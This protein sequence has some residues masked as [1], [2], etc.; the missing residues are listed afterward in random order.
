M[1]PIVLK[2]ELFQNLS[3]FVSRWRKFVGNM[4][5]CFVNHFI[6]G[7]ACSEWAVPNRSALD[8]LGGAGSPWLKET[9][10]VIL[11][12]C[13]KDKRGGR[14]QGRGPKGWDKAQRHQMGPGGTGGVSWPKRRWFTWAFAVSAEISFCRDGAWAYWKTGPPRGWARAQSP[15][16]G[17]HAL[18]AL[19]HKDSFPMLQRRSAGR[20]IAA[21]RSSC[22]APRRT[23]RGGAGSQR[24][25][26]WTSPTSGS[27]R[28]R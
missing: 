17:L 16:E 4:P 20:A 9:L 24:P 2:G 7:K 8:V 22:G 26:S 21:S 27:A 3:R 25:S 18:E 6:C 19:A 1:S 13:S 15:L 23:A 28:R 5:W 10:A 14:L 11:L 12:C